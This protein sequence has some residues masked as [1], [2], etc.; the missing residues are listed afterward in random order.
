MLVFIREVTYMLLSFKIQIQ[1]HIKC[2][3]ESPEEVMV[4]ECVKDLHHKHLLVY[5]DI[6]SYHSSAN[7]LQTSDI[8]CYSS[9]FI[10]IL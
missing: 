1:L 7:L 9:T 10:T 6:Y 2:R 4:V 8:S 5:A 3:N